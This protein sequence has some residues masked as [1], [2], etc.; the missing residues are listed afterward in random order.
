MATPSGPTFGILKITGPDTRGIVA[1]FSQ[2]LYGH[3]CGIQE[4]EQ[5]TDKTVNRFFQRIKFD[6]STMH[7]D[8]ITI[9]SGITEVCNR[10]N[11]DHELNWGESKKKIAIMVSKY[12]HC[13]WELLLRH[14]AGELDCDISII[15]SNHPDLEYI[16]ESFKIP[17]KVFKITK[18]TKAEQEKKELDLLKNTYGVDLV[19]L[20]RYMQII[21]DDFCRE[22]DHKVINIH[23]SFLPAFIGGKPYHRAHERGVKLIGATAHYATA[24]LDEG[25]IIEQVSISAKK[26]NISCI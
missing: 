4:S 17:F 11:M 6:Y 20:A 13:L 16:A 25:P 19:I 21:S 23:H 26:T 18:V 1:A 10:F 24:E 22:F 2:L 7:T 9:Q 15:I 14:Q 5:S 3:G 8:R 12:D